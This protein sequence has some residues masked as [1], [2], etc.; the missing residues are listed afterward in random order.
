M[1]CYADV[2]SFH[3]VMSYKRI[4]GNQAQVSCGAGHIKSPVLKIFLNKE[5][6]AVF[7]AAKCRWFQMIKEK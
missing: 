5:K 3:A 1:L 4:R 6:L 7:Q 2:T